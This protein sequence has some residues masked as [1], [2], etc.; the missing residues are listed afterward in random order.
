MERRGRRGPVQADQCR[1]DGF[2]P[3]GLGVGK[4]QPVAQTLRVFW[5]RD[6]KR[7]QAKE[8]VAVQPTLGFDRDK[9]AE[10]PWLADAAKDRVQ[11]AASAHR[12]RNVARMQRR[13]ELQE[14][15]AHAL[16]REPCESIASTDRRG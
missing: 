8:R 13:Q 16:A 6:A 12:L 9:T 10:T 11:N 4:T 14:F 2:Q 5:N 3:V 1:G 7:G 15:G